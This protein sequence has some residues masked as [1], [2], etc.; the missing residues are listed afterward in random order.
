M[1]RLQTMAEVTIFKRQ[2]QS[3]YL[4]KLGQYEVFLALRERTKL[5]ESLFKYCHNLRLI[6]QTGGHAYHI[7]KEAARNRGIHLALGRH[8]TSPTIVI[9]E[10]VFSFILA[11]VRN[12]PQLASQMSKGDWPAAMGGSL[13]GR[14]IGILGYGR[15]GKPVARIAKAFGME[16]VAWDRRTSV[17]VESENVRRL[18]LD[19]LLACS[20]V[21][22]I[23]LQLSSESQGLLNRDRIAKMKSG[24]FLINTSRGAIVDED[25]LIEALTEKRLGGAGLDVFVVEPLPA[26]SRLRN[27][28]NVILTPHIGWKVKDVLHEFVEIAANQLSEWL[29]SQHQI[30]K[31]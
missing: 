9:P 30:S 13:V 4:P 24:A 3:E 11:L 7:N 1:A 8:V 18:P 22:S 31:L 15:L 23:H 19:D 12:I 10:L 28:P 25:A 29:S 16:V 14:T 6:L 17:S 26:S 2:L 21:V 5:D 27:L 20:D